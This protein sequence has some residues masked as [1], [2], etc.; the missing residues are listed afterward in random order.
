[1]S[2]FSEA[3]ILGTSKFLP[4]VSAIA[5]S[6]EDHAD[7]LVIGALLLVTVLGF[8]L[9]LGQISRIIINFARLRKS[10]NEKTTQ[11]SSK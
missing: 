10:S 11:Q 2:V 8:L 5:V 9:Q 1:M 7:P 6:W 3:I 4:A